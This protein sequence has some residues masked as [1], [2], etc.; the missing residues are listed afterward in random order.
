MKQGIRQIT[1]IKIPYNQH[2]IK[3][4]GKCMCSEVCGISCSSFLSTYVQETYS[5]P[6]GQH[7]KPE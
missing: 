7:T 3:V 6:P 5:K 2:T 4:I 1:L